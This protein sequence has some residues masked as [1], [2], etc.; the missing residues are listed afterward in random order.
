MKPLFSEY[1]MQCILKAAGRLVQGQPYKR[2]MLIIRPSG[3]RVMERD[4]TVARIVYVV[5]HNVYFWENGKWQ[6][7]DGNFV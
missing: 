7:S 2:P 4:N 1:T 5:G 6:E 3:W